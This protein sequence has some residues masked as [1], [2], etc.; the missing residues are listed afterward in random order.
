MKF[1]ST[2]NRLSPAS[3][4]GSS[5]K[6]ASSNWIGKL[7]IFSV[8]S[9]GSLAGCIL[10]LRNTV[11]WVSARPTP[12]VEAQPTSTAATRPS[13]E[14]YSAR[15]RRN[16]AFLADVKQE[17]AAFLRDRQQR[18]WMERSRQ[19]PDHRNAFAIWKTQVE[20]LE[21]KV[22]ELAKQEDFYDED[23]N[24][25]KDSILWHQQQ[26]LESLSQDPPPTY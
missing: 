26:R 14:D 24:V 5:Q 17:D 15:K 18:V 2:H 7:L 16:E 12:M 1:T 10:L 25:L 9:V 6:E 22:A 3:G 20:R 4:T 11:Q 13:D 23:G 8:L 19:K 21:N